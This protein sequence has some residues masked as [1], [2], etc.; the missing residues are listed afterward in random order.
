VDSDG[1]GDGDEFIVFIDQQR[2]AAVPLLGRD[3][4]FE[5]LPLNI[6]S[7]HLLNERLQSCFLVTGISRVAGQADLLHLLDILE[8]Q[9][10]V[11]SPRYPPISE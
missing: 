8:A 7:F 4:M 6:V 3:Q 9:L 10:N 1:D 2:T 5:Y 11:G